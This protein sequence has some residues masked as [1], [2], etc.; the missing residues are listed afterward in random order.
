[1]QTMTRVNFTLPWDLYSDLKDRVSIGQRSNFVASAVRKELKNKKK[2]LSYSES[3]RKLAGTISAK[4]HPEWK[5]LDSIVAWVNEGRAAANRDYSYI[6]Y[7]DKK[8]R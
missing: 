3:L 4:N 7:G 1:M 6:P 2:K 5:D 8:K